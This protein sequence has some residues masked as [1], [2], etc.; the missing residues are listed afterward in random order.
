MS[1]Y[2]LVNQ[3]VPRK[4]WVDIAERFR[5]QFS[6]PFDT[7]TIRANTAQARDLLGL[8]NVMDDLSRAGYYLNQAFTLEKEDT[9]SEDHTL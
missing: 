8:V 2:L 4:K 5:K 9:P 1:V 7:Q 3:R 6:L